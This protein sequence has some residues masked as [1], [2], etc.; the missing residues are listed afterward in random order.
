MKYL[1]RV[2]KVFFALINPWRGNEIV[3]SIMSNGKLKQI[4]RTSWDELLWG[5]HSSLMSWR[6]ALI[7]YD[8][9]IRQNTHSP[10]MATQARDF[11]EQSKQAVWR[12]EEAL[13]KAEFYKSADRQVIVGLRDNLQETTTQLLQSADWLDGTTRQILEKD[14]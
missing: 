4:N 11:A 2:F 10:G 1:I 6:R 14:N 8:F 7:S 13:E 12:L 3:V 5:P 9:H